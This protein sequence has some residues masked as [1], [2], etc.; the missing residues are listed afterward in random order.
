MLLRSTA[1]GGMPIIL[2]HK[3]D[4][5][6]NVLDKSAKLQFPWLHPEDDED[7]GS[8]NVVSKQIQ[9]IIDNYDSIIQAAKGGQQVPEE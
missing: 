6:K 7:E 3:F 2:E 8:A 5:L 4:S 9:H 1:L